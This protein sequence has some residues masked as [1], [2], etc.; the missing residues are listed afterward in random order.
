MGCELTE[1]HPNRG[2]TMSFRTRLLTGET[3]VGTFVKNTSPHSI[4]IVAGAGF[5]FV[6]LDAEHAPFDRQS[7]DMGLL[8]TRASD[9]YGVVRVR[10]HSPAGILDA[11]DLGA[12]AVLVPH[13]TTA[14]DATAIV[15]ASR[16][17]GAR[18]YSNSP[19]AGGYGALDMWSHVDRADERVAVIAM[20]EDPE[21]VGNIEQILDVDGL[22]A[23]FV[24]RGDLSVALDDREPGAPRVADATRRVIDAAAAAGKQVVLFVAS[25]HEALAVKDDGVV[26][27]ILSSDQGLLRVA[28]TAAIRE[29]HTS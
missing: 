6:V 17:S 13:V 28:A 8:A 16:H 24:G 9:I 26:T 23:V 5:D 3:S 21:A 10:D 14:A 29:I 25:A 12:D 22:D 19:R 1:H 11:L 27:V 18:G 4:E 15:R 2:T 20:I 7:V